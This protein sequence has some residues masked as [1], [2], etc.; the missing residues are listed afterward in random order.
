[1]I[2]LPNGFFIILDESKAIN[3]HNRI[4]NLSWWIILIALLISFSA[5]F[6]LTFIPTPQKHKVSHYP[7]LSIIIP[8]R[9]EE[10]RIPTLLSSINQAYPFH[11]EWIVVD[12]H[13]SD[14][15]VAIARSFGAKVISAPPLPQ[16]W[17]GKPWACYQ[18]AKAA[19]GNVLMFLDADTRLRPHGLTR[20][21]Q[22]FLQTSTPMSVQ[23]YHEMKKGYEQFSLFFNLIVMMTTGLFTPFQQKLKSASFFGPCQIM[24]KEDYWSIDGHASGKSAILED[25]AIGKALQEKTK[26]QIRAIGGKGTIHFRMYEEGF[27]SLIEGW[28][29]NFSTGAS[30]MP[31]WIL[32]LVSLWITG[33]FVLILSGFAPFM[34]ENGA[35]LFGY[36]MGGLLTFLM[37]RKIGSFSIVSIVTYPIQ[38]IFFVG[39]F[40]FSSQKRK[41][42]N[43][44][45]KGRDID[46]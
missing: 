15:T 41:K 11:V 43:V 2:V 38:L 22:T 37:A 16:G 17:L 6:L 5:L 24:S 32:V 7:S 39:L 10:K 14:S 23:P 1:M 35:Y 21:M 40:I 30:L 31:T 19:Q 42:K 25:I 34:W 20:L 28:S 33:M 8:A 13:S 27:S 36:F 26:K 4:M 3:R 9:N 29:K 44:S 12:D 18:G 45:W 46:L